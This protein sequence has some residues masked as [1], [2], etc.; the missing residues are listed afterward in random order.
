[1]KN[2]EPSLKSAL[3]NSGTDLKSVPEWGQSA[4]VLSSQTFQYLVMHDP[5]VEHDQMI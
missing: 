3:K 2:D 4:A 5:V 1:M